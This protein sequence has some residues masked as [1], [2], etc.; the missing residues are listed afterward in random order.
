MP[1][2]SCRD[3][4]SHLTPIASSPLATPSFLTTL[5]RT[6]TTLSQTSHSETLLRDT[7]WPVI[8]KR[9]HAALD[10]GKPIT[11]A[12]PNRGLPMNIVVQT[13]KASWHVDGTWPIGPN[14]LQV[15]EEQSKKRRGIE[16]GPEG[17]QD[18][19]PEDVASRYRERG[20]AIE[21]P[22]TVV[23]DDW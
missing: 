22:E 19:S 13:L 18:P 21:E 17:K 6:R 14:A 9:I 2:G 1:N 20:V 8:L 11:G 4:R 7:A 3:V 23:D 5:A 16:K 12:G 10:T 15:M